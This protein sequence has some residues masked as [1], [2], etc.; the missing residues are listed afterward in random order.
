MGL[1]DPVPL[2]YPEGQST[3]LFVCV[4]RPDPVVVLLDRER[5]FRVGFNHRG[6]QNAGKKKPPRLRINGKLNTL[7]VIAVFRGVTAVLS[8]F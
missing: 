5:G 7:R 6:P 2:K 4:V 3:L 1:A 8:I